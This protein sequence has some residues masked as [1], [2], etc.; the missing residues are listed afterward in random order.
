M[1][2]SVTPHYRISDALMSYLTVARGAKAGGFN[3]GFGKHRLRRASSA[4]EHVTHYELGARGSSRNGRARF[5]A[6]VFHT[7]YADYQDAAFVAAQF[8]VG[9]A[10][11]VK[12]ERGRVRRRDAARREPYGRLPGLRGRPYLCIEQ[13]GPVL[14][15]T[16]AGRR[17][18]RFVRSV[19]GASHSSP[20]L[21]HSRRRAI[22]TRR[23][24]GG[25]VRAP[26]L[27][28][29]RSLQHEFFCGSAP[30]ATA[31]ADVGLRIGAQ[32]GD[33]YESRVWGENLLDEEVT[34]FDALLNLFN[35]VSYQSYLAEPR[36]YGATL[37][38]RF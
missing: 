1:T 7:E 16:S 11:Q 17:V 20:G 14:P 23:R 5:S 8:S 24:L 30:R 10:E 34:Y 29:D 37:R 4:D 26:R 38:V 9:N 35:D 2:W 25:S 3:T 19:G 32:F 18:S 15:G 31:D 12:L 22:R 13:N 6:A 27:V 33:A 28:L 36:R 21:E